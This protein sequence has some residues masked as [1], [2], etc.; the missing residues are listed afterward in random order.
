MRSL[1]TCIAY[2]H[3]LS[4]VALAAAVCFIGVYS[5]F[6]LGVHAYFRERRRDRLFWG[7]ACV[8]AMS[9]ATWATHFIAM[10]AFRPGV[11]TA[12]DPVLTATSL[13]VAVTGIG[14]G[15]AL[16]INTTRVLDR[17]GA[18]AVIGVGISAMHYVGIAAYEVAG[19][20]R[21]DA[22]VIFVSVSASIALSAAAAVIALATRRVLRNFA[23]AVLLVAICSLHFI[24]MSAIAVVPDPTVL[25]SAHAL[26]PR[27]VGPV[28]A[29]VT[30]LVMMVAASGLWVAQSRRRQRK[31]ERQ[32]LN[33][34]ADV[35]IEGLLICD[36]E[37]VV[38]A[39]K[40]AQALVG[41]DADVIKGAL[42]QTLVP[43][44]RVADVPETVEADAVLCSASGE[45]IP[46][47]IVRRVV[48]IERRPH[49]V[50]AVRDQRERLRSEA[51]IRSLAFSDALTGL[52]N[53]ARF[54]AE[55]GQRMQ[56]RRGRDQAFALL[57]LD[58]DR[59]KLVND[60]L[61][62]GVGDKLLQRVAGRLAAALREQDLMARL[63]GDEFAILQTDITDP[64]QARTLA[65]RVVDFLGRPFIID[66]QVINIGASVGVAVAPSDGDTPETLLRN[67][68]LALY[69]AK[70]D[71]RN[72]YR[73]FEAA[74]DARMQARRALEMD[75]RRATAC[76]EFELHYQPLV[77]ARSRDVLGAEALVRWRD[78]VRGMISPGDFIPLAEETGLISAIGQWVLRTAC[79]EAATWP[80][81]MSVAVNLSP[82][83]F[84]DPHLAD[85]VRG[86][87]S[88]T[89]LN[90]SR[91]ELEITEGVLMANE[92]GTLATLNA[93]RALGVRIAMDDFGTGYSSLS[94]LQRFPFDKIKVDQSFI[95]QVPQNAQA[96]GI[97]RAIITMGA[98]L[99][100]CTTVE[101]VETMEQLAFTAR[102]GCDQVQGYFLS[103]PLTAEAFGSFVQSRVA[104]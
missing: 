73:M 41:L 61:G 72:A 74:L 20:I 35:A 54:T 81:H 92:A 49:S 90:P 66:G 70:A 68:D 50:V 98:C 101:G 59:F 100:I 4:L 80:G 37:V 39:N 104:A 42:F 2:E 11:A 82:V 99:G 22:V 10:L 69:K 23:P 63:G 87:L 57:M 38:S 19:V 17:A 44:V 3:D 40:S 25:L 33:N 97:V 95:R 76:Q 53:R 18:G 102:E 51:E 28:V 48:I 15:I 52:P 12:F 55:L 83:Q 79:A 77:D 1:Y 62:H 91:L 78:P 60:T 56:S 84:R 88:K 8:L 86:V 71:G 34:L 58:L 29:G 96:A 21:W 43:D 5:S 30:L 32:S 24:G 103:R 27:V 93:L 16:S 9:G 89:G 67:A 47:R 46:I 13:I 75:L 65:A 45:A 14:T 36:G 85:M 6:P 7:G 64:E 94:Y 31:Q 26:P